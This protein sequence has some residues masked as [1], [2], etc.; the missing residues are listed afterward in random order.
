MN[1]GPMIANHFKYTDHG[2]YL[3]L[4]VGEGLN[5]CIWKSGCDDVVNYSIV[6]VT[7]RL[8]KISWYSSDMEEDALTCISAYVMTIIYDSKTY[9]YIYCVKKDIVYIMSVHSREGRVYKKDVPLQ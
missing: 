8:K 7:D 5:R 4:G 2:K 6:K 9:Y 1:T 3:S